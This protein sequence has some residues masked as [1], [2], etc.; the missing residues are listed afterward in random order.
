MKRLLYNI[1]LIISG[2]LIKPIRFFRLKTKLRGVCSFPYGAI[3]DDSSTFEG[4]NAVGSGTYFCGSMGYGSYISPHSSIEG[5]IGR[6]CSIGPYVRTNLGIHPT[7]A[8]FA[9]T[10][11]MFFSTRRQ[12]GHTFADK[13][14]FEEFS[15]PIKIG[16][17]CWIGEGAFICGGVTIGDG[18]VVYAHSVVTKDVPP[19]AI[20]AGVP[21]RIIKYRYDKDTVDFLIRTKWWNEPIGWLKE[22]WELLCNIN[23]L[24]EY[25][26]ASD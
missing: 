14:Y 18:A 19:Y 2:W 21:A 23:G 17:D 16:N 10:S 20:V 11:H 3:I 12:N 6:F 22:N 7:G 24:K 13:Q 25:F 1:W 8:P 5:D 9:T 26:N 4:A 15:K